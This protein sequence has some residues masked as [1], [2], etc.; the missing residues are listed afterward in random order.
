MLLS[1]SYLLCYN[2]SCRNVFIT[3][4]TTKGKHKKLD[5]ELRSRHSQG[6]TNLVICNGAVITKPTS[7]SNT[8]SVPNF[9]TINQ[10]S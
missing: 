8:T 10:H 1:H 3:P 5:S 2:D 9:G 6:E 4:D 7:R